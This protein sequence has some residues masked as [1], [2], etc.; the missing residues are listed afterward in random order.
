MARAAL[1][2]AVATPGSRRHPD[3]YRIFARA[4]MR[5]FMQELDTSLLGLAAECQLLDQPIDI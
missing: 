3:H 2:H 1:A 4:R 5:A